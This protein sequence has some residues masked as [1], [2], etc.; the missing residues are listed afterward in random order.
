MTLPMSETSFADH[1]V[2]SREHPAEE[3]FVTGTFDKWTKSVQLD[4]VDNVFQKTVDLKDAST[5]IYYKVGLTESPS[6]ASSGFPPRS[7]CIGHAG[8]APHC[9]GPWPP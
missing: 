1:A 4:K 6:S 2:Y 3:V 8:M 7:P 9:L 5:K